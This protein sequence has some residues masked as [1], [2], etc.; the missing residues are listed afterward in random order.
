VFLLLLLFSPHHQRAAAAVATVNVQ[1]NSY[2]TR[3]VIKESHKPYSQILF[4]FTND[5]IYTRD[6]L[7]VLLMWNRREHSARRKGQ[8][9]I[10]NHQ[11]QSKDHRP[12]GL[13]DFSFP[14]EF[15]FV[16]LLLLLL[17]LFTLLLPWF[18][19]QHIMQRGNNQPPALVSVY[20]T[21]LETG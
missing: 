14:I 21:E 4:S 17:L 8:T 5:R 11:H 18:V 20:R 7:F 13:D 3:Q 16:C 9:H 1:F 2:F 6:E 19:N 10:H 12:F 15:Y